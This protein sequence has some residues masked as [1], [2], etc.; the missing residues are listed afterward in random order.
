MERAIALLLSLLLTPWL[1]LFGLVQTLRTG[2]LGR[3]QRNADT[4]I[5]ELRW[6]DQRLE[7][8]L[9]SVALGYLRL[10]GP[11]PGSAASQKLPA[12]LY[13]PEQL[14]AGM[15][16]GGGAG[17]EQ[18]SDAAYFAQAKLL[19]RLGLVCRSWLALVYRDSAANSTADEVRMFGVQFRNTSLAQAVAAITEPGPAQ[20]K[21]RRVFFVNADCLNLAY[22]DRDYHFL[23][24]DA[25]LVLP[26]G[27]GV[28]L[29]LKWLGTR[30]K[31]NLNGT[32][33]FPHICERA[34][35]DGLKLYLLG[36]APDIAQRTAQN[37]MLRFPG[38]QIV[39]WRDGFF[40]A[41]QADEVIAEI[42]S[43]EADLLLV[44]MGAP[45][46]E[47]WLSDHAAALT[48]RA[49]IGVGGLFDYYSGDVARAPLWLREL[50][51][52]WVWR[53]VQQP[54]DKW[55]RYVLGNPIFLWRVLLQRLSLGQKSWASVPR[56]DASSHWFRQE[57]TGRFETARTAVKIG[58]WRWSL[59]L[60]RG[61][62]RGLDVAVSGVGLALLSPLLLTVA[63]L[64]GVTSPGPV[65]FK[66]IRV[67]LR[68]KHFVMYKFRSMCSDAEKRRQ[69][70]ESE[71][72]SPEAVLFK[73]KTDP[74]VTPI[75]RWLRR[76]SIDELPQMFNVLNGTMSLVGPRPALPAEV[77]SYR[78]DHLKRLQGKPGLTCWWQ[79]SGRSDLSF[80]EQIDL[81]MRYMQQLSVGQDLRLLARTV[82]AVISGR[83]AA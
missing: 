75:G 76:F 54:G 4:Q 23:L 58:L 38:L 1:F 32:D 51:L 17:V 2:A 28:R 10:T 33:L 83:G 69:H 73:I 6:S 79:V 26:D 9:W 56:D 44:G 24:H 50:G 14:Q 61:L 29:G 36:G 49:G 47:R 62:K 77:D 46:Q 7:L 16:I 22:R 5:L 30:M 3:L 80:Q 55:R 67:G 15:G 41:L 18:G 11:A 31:D 70:L 64:V 71:N 81:D 43:S 40:D 59:L 20:D 8:G 35:A 25:D 57:S 63:V 78:S 21:M 19:D 34:A 68:G 65:L 12:G 42:N 27:S 82:P 74:R 13:S 53:I 72:E 37:M 39:G 52:E 45:R 66:Q 60:S 48:V